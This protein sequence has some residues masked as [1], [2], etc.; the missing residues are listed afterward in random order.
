MRALEREA[1]KKDIVLVAPV[2]NQ[3]GVKAV[4]NRLICREKLVEQLDN[5]NNLSGKVRNHIVSQT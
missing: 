2:R 3:I 1:R 4:Q 5:S